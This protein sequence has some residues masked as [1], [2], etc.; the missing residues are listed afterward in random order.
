MPGRINEI[1]V[2]PVE[3]TNARTRSSEATVIATA[4]DVMRI[5]AVNTAKRASLCKFLNKKE[6]CTSFGR[7]PILEVEGD[8]L[9]GRDA[10]RTLCRGSRDRDGLVVG[11]RRASGRQ[12][13]L[14]QM[15][16]RLNFR[17]LK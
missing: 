17:T 9:V 7:E 14:D 11:M 10:K 1:A 12:W 15:W 8:G 16:R 3:P 13:L 2:E 4:Y 6:G 5:M